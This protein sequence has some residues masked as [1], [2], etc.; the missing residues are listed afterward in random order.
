VRTIASKSGSKQNVVTA[1]FDE[2]TVVFMIQRTL[3]EVFF[4]T[5][6]PRLELRPAAATHVGKVRERHEDHHAVIRN[7][8]SRE[9]L[10]TNLPDDVIAFPDDEALG[11]IVAAGIRGVACGDVAS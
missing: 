5:D 10:F 3:A 1:A 4:V 6:E 7:T 11:L 2:E 8:R 9:V